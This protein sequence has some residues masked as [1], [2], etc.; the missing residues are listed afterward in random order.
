MCVNCAS[1]KLTTKGSL[2]RG[3]CTVTVQIT[4][5][6]GSVLAGEVLCWTRDPP[7]NGEA[8]L[9]GNAIWCLT[10]FGTA[11]FRLRDSVSEE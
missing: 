10:S 1:R 7:A 3:P 9:E 4:S 8:G 5:M 6:C 2:L 11:L